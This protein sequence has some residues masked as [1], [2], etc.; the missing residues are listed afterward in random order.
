M[1]EN[2]DIIPKAPVAPSMLP[3]FIGLGSLPN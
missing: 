1:P 3:M 2:Y